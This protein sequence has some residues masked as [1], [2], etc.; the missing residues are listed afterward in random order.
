VAASAFPLAVA[1][2]RAVADEQL[3]QLWYE[4]ALCDPQRELALTT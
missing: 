4:L 1:S 3:E 2:S